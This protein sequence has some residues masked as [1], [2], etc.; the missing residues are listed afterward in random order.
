MYQRRPNGSYGARAGYHDDILAGT[1]RLVGT[2]FEKI[3][4][5]TTRLLTDRDA[6]NG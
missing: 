2:D 5:E 1:V 4:T 6:Y 3:T